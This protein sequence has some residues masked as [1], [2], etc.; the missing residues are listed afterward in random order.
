MV[1]SARC[2]FGM[3]VLP[4]GRV[5][6]AGE[7]HKATTLCTAE[8]SST[9]TTAKS[10]HLH[11]ASMWHGARSWHGLCTLRS[12]VVAVGGHDGNTALATAERNTPHSNTWTP[13][14]PMYEPR[15]GLGLCRLPCGASSSFLSTGFVFR[16][17][18]PP[19]CVC[20]V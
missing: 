12:S 20:S 1:K 9:P 19:S 15:S 8:V 14:P 4:D 18:S 3:A 16:K 5:I 2:Q 7:L 11:V 17:K 10:L 13:M 6:S